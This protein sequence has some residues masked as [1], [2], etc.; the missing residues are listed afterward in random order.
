MK[1]K[2]LDLL[3]LW[4]FSGYDSV[5]EVA[6]GWSLRFAEGPPGRVLADGPTAVTRPGGHP[7][8]SFTPEFQR[9]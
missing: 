1:L 3:M 7:K 9:I 8:K 5:R 2:K 6:Q 4:R